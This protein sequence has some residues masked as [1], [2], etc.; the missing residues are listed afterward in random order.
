M[1]DEP[2]DAERGVEYVLG[3][4]QIFRRDAVTELG[5]TDRRIWYGHDDADRCYAIRMAGWD[6]V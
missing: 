3:A 1:A 4:C 2:H 6:V 5:G